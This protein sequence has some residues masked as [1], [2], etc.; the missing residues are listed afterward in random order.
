MGLELKR[1]SKQYLYYIR[2]T[3]E[4]T[5]ESSN[6]YF[7]I[8]D[9]PKYLGEGK[10]SFRIKPQP[11]SL[12]PNTKIDVE[13]IDANGNS[14]YWEIPPYK[15]SDNSRVISVWV[16][17]I[18]DKRYNTPDGECEIIIVGTLPNNGLVRWSRK[19]AVIKSKQ[20]VSEII[21]NPKELPIVNVSSSVSTFTDKPQTDGKL[22]KVV[23]TPTI[24]YIKSTFNDTVSVESSVAAFNGEMVNGSLEMDF[25]STTLFPRLK[26]NQ[27]QPT[28]VTSSIIRVVSDKILQLETPITKSDTRSTD[29]IHTYEYSD[30]TLP[31]TI[32]YVSTGSDLSSQNQIAIANITLT[33]VNPIVGRIQA[34]ATSIKSAGIPNSE[35]QYLARTAVANTSSFTYQVPIPTEQLKD[36]KTLRIEYVSQNGENSTTSTI[37]ENIVFDGGNVYIGG[38]QSLITGSFNIGNT[39]GQGIEMAGHSSGYLKS[40]GYD[41]F[42]NALNGSGPGG[43]LLFSGSGNLNVGSDTYDGVGLDLVANSAS[44]FR[45]TTN[46]GGNLDIRTDSFFIGNPNTQ[47]ISGSNS[48]IEISSSFFHLN[49]KDNEALIGGF[50]ITPNAISSSNELLQ[51]KSNGQITGSNIRLVTNV[52]G[53]NY[54]V[55]DTNK[56][57]IDAKNVGR[58]L[59]MSHDEHIFLNS[60]GNA[61]KTVSSDKITIIWQGLRHETRVNISFQGLFEKHGTGKAVGGFQGSLYTAISGSDNAAD[62]YYDNWQT[63]R[64]DKQMA[65]LGTIAP[66]TPYSASESNVASDAFT[67]EIADYTDGLTTYN[68]EKYQTQLFKLELEPYVQNLLTSTGTSRVKI[69]NISV[70]TSRGLASTFNVLTQAPAGGGD[71]GGV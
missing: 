51:I 46:G 40:V 15:D 54:E 5:S 3:I 1:K 57:I 58:Q 18:E 41:G 23:T 30:G 16:Y 70:W 33:N 11:N 27:P 63:L 28:N 68:H 20:A 62:T 9:F 8:S 2:P 44:Y 29:S 65:T 50:V 47:F 71:F 34:V 14:V 35:Y 39:I 24:R 69:K 66:T 36:P 13:V 64:S 52:G 22:T 48:N 21:F 61:G 10:N 19:T 31:S 53:T 42:T 25:T 37:I 59:Y 43:F 7:G 60:N 49:P 56:G 17:D 4:D 26:G 12:K 55:L 6:Q 67:F 38:D 45:Y 32:R